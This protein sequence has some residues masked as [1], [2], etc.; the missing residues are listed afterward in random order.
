L[1]HIPFE[2]FGS[3]VDTQS[4]IETVGLDVYIFLDFGYEL[5]AFNDILQVHSKTFPLNRTNETNNDTS[6]RHP[7][8][9]ILYYK[10]EA[11]SHNFLRNPLDRNINIYVRSK[12][13]YK[14]VSKCCRRLW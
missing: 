6:N 13:N 11:Q 10:G 4:L 5:N 3:V 12:N 7:S 14:T 2:Q 1:D 9:T 8:I